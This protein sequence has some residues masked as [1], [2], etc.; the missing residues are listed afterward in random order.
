L[1]AV[2]SAAVRVVLVDDH[3]VL[4][5]G[6]RDFL[7]SLPGY[8]IV[9]EASGALAALRM[10]ESTRPD[11]VLMDIA[12]PGIDGIAATREILWRMP[13]TRVIVLSARDRIHDVEAAIDAG[14]IGYVLKADPPETL[15]D[16]LDH[17]ARGLVYVSPR[18]AQRMPAAPPPRPVIDV[19]DVSAERELDLFRPAADRPPAPPKRTRSDCVARKVVQARPNR[20]RRKLGRRTSVSPTRS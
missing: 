7:G 20:T 2:P 14:A 11:V 15:A 1:C 6:V 16:A 3:E 19:L 13:T 4:R 9:G 17:A 18:L 5:S 8:E 10:V 12:L